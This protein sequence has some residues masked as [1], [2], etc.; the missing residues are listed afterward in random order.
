MT[1]KNAIF[2]WI[3]Y[4]EVLHRRAIYFCP[5]I[6]H[7]TAGTC[8]VRT[9]VAV[10][11]VVLA[12][13]HFNPVS[14]SHCMLHA[15]LS[16]PFEPHRFQLFK[17]IYKFAEKE[18]TG[19]TQSGWMRWYK[20]IEKQ[21]IFLDY[22]WPLSAIS[23]RLFCVFWSRLALAYS[24]LVA[25]APHKCTSSVSALKQCHRHS[26]SL[27][28]PSLMNECSILRRM[29]NTLLLILLCSFGI[30]YSISVERLVYCSSFK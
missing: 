1:S 6:L 30:L 26:P 8:C 28:A 14:Y 12:K 21:N 22:P 10:N 7:W 4:G 11:A 5:I 29:C 24:L 15:T 25:C 2:Q 13:C 16:A 27:S 23:I 18:S 17:L 20:W 9:S 3:Q 19:T